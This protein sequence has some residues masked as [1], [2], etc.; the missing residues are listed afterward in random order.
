MVLRT[1]IIILYTLPTNDG[2]TK[3]V[4][5]KTPTDRYGTV[6]V[7]TTSLDHDNAKHIVLI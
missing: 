1:I 2:I 3:F 6:R 4:T 5:I 7:Q